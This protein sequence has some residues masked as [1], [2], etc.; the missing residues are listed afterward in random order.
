MLVSVC[1]HDSRHSL[2]LSTLCHACT[3][4]CGS[5]HGVRGPY[6]ANGITRK[7]C[8]RLQ[9]IPFCFWLS[10]AVFALSSFVPLAPVRPR[11]RLECHAVSRLGRR[12]HDSTRSCPSLVSAPETGLCRVPRSAGTRVAW[13][14]VLGFSRRTASHLVNVISEPTRSAVADATRTSR[15]EPEARPERE[16]RNPKP[17][18]VC[19]ST[20]T[21]GRLVFR[22]RPTGAGARR[23]HGG[24][25][26]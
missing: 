19:R 12:G 7:H 20:V 16:R 22:P 4:T 13:P 26:I 24:G 5:K 9:Y 14:W 8:V 1:T 17:Y 11:S 3:H 21:L 18:P 10:C 25:C 23:S 15:A 2:S 6:T